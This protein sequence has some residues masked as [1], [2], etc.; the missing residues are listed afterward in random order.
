M[1][2]PAAD[3]QPNP[4]FPG[5][6]GYWVE[7]AQFRGLKSFGTYKCVGKKCSGRWSSAHATKDYEQGCRRCER[8]AF[9]HL[10]WVNNASGAS[11]R[12]R[13]NPDDEKA[14]HDR[15]RCQAC[16]AGACTVDLENAF[17]VFEF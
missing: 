6:D 2:P 4:P 5:A 14:V 1:P 15:A 12:E 9:P 7:R 11:R 17:A 16:A 13:K 10:M 3:E 8:L